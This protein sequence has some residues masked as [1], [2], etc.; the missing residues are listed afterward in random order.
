MNDSLYTLRL[1]LR[2]SVREMRGGLS[3]FLIFIA[4]I[5]LGVAAIGGVNSV[6]R[7]ITT[8]V[9]SQGQ[10]LLGGDIRFQLVHRELDEREQAFLDSLGTVAHSAGMRSMARLG[11]GSDQTLVE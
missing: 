10:A 7:A 3:G 5:A 1:A 6:A 2:F 11:D 8:G 4:C 9:E